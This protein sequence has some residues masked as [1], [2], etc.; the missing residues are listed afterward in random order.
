MVDFNA[1]EKPYFVG[2]IGINH[3]GDMSIVKKL[4]DAVFACN[5]DCAKFQKRDPATCVPEH[6]KNIMRDTPWGRISYLDYRYKVELTAK[7]YSDINSYCKQKPIDWTA[8][9]W[10]IPSLE[11][12]TQFNPPFI[13]IPSALVTDLELIRRLCSTNIPLLISTGMSTLEEIDSAVNLIISKT[14]NPVIMHCNSAYPT[15]VDQINLRVIDTLRQRYGCTIGY[16]G[17]EEDLE[18]TVLAVSLGAKVIERHITLSKK[19]WGTDQHA[20]LEILAMDMLYK[21]CADIEKMLG[22][23]D[24]Q[25]TEAEIKTRK[26][27]RK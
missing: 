17:H 27:L 21:R 13:K 3:N 19:L 9:V 4:L 6:Q 25:V 11:F 26:R 7:N 5:W 1:L 24:K 2:E 8:S 15:P 20:S 23:P 22:S 10:D 16:S 12:I 14:H 18:P